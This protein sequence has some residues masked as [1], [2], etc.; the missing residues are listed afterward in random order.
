MAID[1][2]EA[3]HALPANPENAGTQ[4]DLL[5]HDFRTLLRGQNIRTEAWRVGDELTCP[6]RDGAPVL[7]SPTAEVSS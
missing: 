3:L 2:D 1:L 4:R 5:R 7:T 6:G